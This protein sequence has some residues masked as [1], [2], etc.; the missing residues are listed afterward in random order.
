M[1]DHSFDLRRPAEVRAQE[2]TAS[3]GRGISCG[4]CRDGFRAWLLGRWDRQQWQASGIADPEH[5]DIAAYVESVRQTKIA[6]GPGAVLAEAL[7]LL[8]AGPSDA[9]ASSARR[10]ARES[11]AGLTDYFD[12][13]SANDPRGGK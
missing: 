12:H 3:K 13:P 4:G 7:S 9:G 5:F 11:A 10:L 1:E 6:K 2:E 8:R